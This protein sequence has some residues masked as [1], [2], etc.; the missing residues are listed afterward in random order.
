LR[1]IAADGYE[2]EFKISSPPAHGRLAEPVRRSKGSISVLYTHDGS[3]DSLRDSFTFR[4]KTGPKKAWATRLASIEILEPPPRL[5]ARPEEL[6]FSDVF[7]GETR[8]LP[9]RIVNSGGGILEVS[10]ETGP[11]WSTSVEMPLRLA[12]SESIDVPVAFS[13]NA[14]DLQKGRLVLKS[15]SGASSAV[16]LQGTGR[17]RFEAPPIA[18]FDPDSA[19]KTILLPVTNR[20]REPLE[21]TISTPPTLSAPPTATIP[22]AAAIQLPLT[23]A[24]RPY[25]EKF[26]IL[27]LSDSASTL[28]VKLTLPPPPPRLQWIIEGEADL[29]PVVSESRVKLNARLANIGS[30]PA[31]VT[32]AGEG[33]FLSQEDSAGFKIDGGGEKTVQ[34]EWRLPRSPGPAKA[35][36]IATAR[37][38]DPAQVTWTAI[39]TE[40]PGAVSANGNQSANPA[41]TPPP[42]NVLTPAAQAALDSRRPA[43]IEY[44]LEPNWRTATAIVSWARTAPGPVDF[45]IQVVRPARSGMVD[46]NPFED[47]L[48]VPDEIP[49]PK[50]KDEWSTLSPDVTRIEKL[51]DGRWQGR[52]PDLEPG[53]HRVNIIAVEPNSKRGE[54]R[55]I[56]IGVGKIPTPPALR[57]ILV[58][59]LLFLLTYLLRN[60]LAGLFRRSVS[61]D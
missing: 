19:D 61:T 13:P 5:D 25:T 37:G 36:I 8:S 31:S 15:A 45:L 42:L 35:S 41:P 55:E 54:G 9:L 34:A 17:R 39:V 58:A 33:L 56:V 1:A 51:P 18:T 23:L 6:D 27:T 43:N 52:V 57:W 53:F 38:A 28:D 60:R 21:L 44:R 4:F 46:K 40:A 47:R 50:L 7:I 32:L 16:T 14:E 12:E 24:S 10:I 49:T 26:A 11:P 30:S 59:I 29:G 22:P 48:K 2:A 3:A 20:T